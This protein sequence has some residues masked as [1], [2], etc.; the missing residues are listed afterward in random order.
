MNS[1]QKDIIIL[2]KE[3]G[4]HLITEEIIT[5]IPEIKK[6]NHGILNLFLLHTSASLTISE[7]TDYRV[8]K[9][10]EKYF[11]NLVPEQ[12]HLYE[13]D[14]EG[15]DDMPAHIKSALIGN[16]LNIPIKNGELIMGTWQGIF[17]C[18]H[19]NN[20][21]SRKILATILGTEK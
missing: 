7:D 1:I 18:E 5:N 12:K 10:L 4:F 11:T 2:K 14:D 13:H 6:I 20:S 21:K 15:L 8:Q 17:L 3:R 9:D 16:N 19:R